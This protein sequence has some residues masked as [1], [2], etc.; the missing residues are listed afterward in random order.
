MIAVSLTAAVAGVSVPSWA[1]TTAVSICERAIPHSVSLIK[2]GKAVP[3]VVDNAADS[4]VINVAKAFASDMAQVAGSEAPPLLTSLPVKGEIVLIGVAGQSPLIDRLI[5]EG[6]LSVDGLDG[7]WEAYRQVV[8]E[9]PFAGIERAL[10]I[11]GADRRG[12]VFGTYDLSEKI[13][14]SPWVWWGDVPVRR[15]ADLYV[16]SGARDDAPKVRYRGIFINDEEPSFGTWARRKFG[17]VNA[18][19]YEHVFDLVLR[20]KGNYLWPAMWGKSIGADDPAT[21]PLADAKGIVLGTSHH[22][23]MTRAQSEWHHDKGD[24]TTGGEWNYVTNGENLRRFWRGGIE[25]MMSKRNATG[26]DQLVTVG[27]RGDGDEPMAEGT[28]TQLLEQIVADQRK[29]IAE[30]TKKPADQTPQVWALY[31][32]VQDYYDKGMTVPDDVTLLFADDNWGQIRRLPEAGSKRSG[33]IGVY[34]HFDYVGGPRSYKWINTNQIEKTW[35]QMDLAY[36][37]GAK[38]LWVVNVGDLKPMEYPIDF[39]LKMAWNPEAMTPAALAAW[40]RQWGNATFGPQLGGQVGDMLTDYARLAARRKPEFLSPESFLIGKASPETLEGGEFGEV[41]A[42]WQ[43]LQNRME[44]VRNQ[45][46]PDQRDAYFQLVE[47]PIA[48]LSNLYQLYYAVAWNRKLAAMNDLR[49]NTFADRA[50]SAFRRDKELTA[51]YHS[52]NGGKWDGMMLQT[53]I[54]FTS[55]NDPKTDIMPAVKRIAANGRQDKPVRFVEASPP[56]RPAYVAIEAPDFARTNQAKGLSWQNI[57]HLGRTS[58]AIVTLPQGQPSTA[59]SDGVRVE[60][61]VDLKRAGEATV[62]LYMVPS[63]DTQG[64]DGLRIGVSVDDGPV[65]TL[66][67]SLKVDGPQWTA[68]VRDNAF[69]L[70]AGLG[71]LATGRHTIKVWRIDDN[72]MV[73]KLVLYTGKLPESYLGPAPA[74]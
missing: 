48:A 59:V 25:R 38:A 30:V 24:T 32:E 5:R 64:K 26:Y 44:G 43:A 53:H 15:K 54:G 45:I 29:I 47:H 40:P 74:R 36:Q 34:Y 58:G 52:L 12:A 37:R 50:E 22:E 51:A 71:R 7:K 72:M 67:M 57:A 19:A 35:Q 62:R 28:A 3:I 17:G 2:N 31:K 13:G 55:W 56:K 61:D 49:A 11:I 21:M 14:V 60:Y 4:A 46:A 68:A 63:L 10:V 73:Q 18:K 16:T 41:V 6:R 20:L 69:P 1:C 27:M 23:P 65:K 8:V 39:F 66:V 70:E 9:K 33:G 42:E